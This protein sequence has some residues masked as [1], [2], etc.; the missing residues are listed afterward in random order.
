[1]SI[2]KRDS[3][4]GKLMIESGMAFSYKETYRPE[5]NLAKSEK[6]GF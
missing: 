1:V 3:N 2:F 5:E 4:I 6:L